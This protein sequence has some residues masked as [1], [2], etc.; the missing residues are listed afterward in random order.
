MTG[1]LKETYQKNSLVENINRRKKNG[2]SRSKKE[3]TVSPKAYQDVQQ[4]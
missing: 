1:P 4:G 2:T 3:A